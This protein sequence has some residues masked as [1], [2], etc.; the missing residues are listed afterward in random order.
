MKLM[1]LCVPLLISG[2]L[3]ANGL[4]AQPAPAHL[5]VRMSGLVAFYHDPG[6]GPSGSGNKAWA[7]FPMTDDETQRNFLN[8]IGSKEQFSSS[9]EP[10]SQHRMV[11][12]VPMRN[13]TGGDDLGYVRLFPTAETPDDPV[14]NT[15]GPSEIAIEVSSGG[16]PVCLD[17]FTSVP[18]LY[19]AGGTA[20]E[21]TLDRNYIDPAIDDADV[22]SWLA[23]RIAFGNG[24]VLFPCETCDAAELKGKKI[25]V[26]KA[27]LTSAAC[28]P[29]PTSY[30]VS[31]SLCEDRSSKQDFAGDVVADHVLL[32]VD[33]P[34][35]VITRRGK[36]D[37]DH[38]RKA[39]G[40]DVCVH[41]LA[42][43][44]Y[45]GRIDI[46]VKNQTAEDLAYLPTP[47][48]LMASTGHFEHGK[49]LYLLT[50]KRLETALLLLGV[51]DSRRPTTVLHR[52]DAVSKGSIGGQQ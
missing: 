19:A 25:E 18:I 3:G 2:I 32:A 31:S 49:L 36:C 16:S 39:A 38:S 4:G 1:R 20:P 51:A 47:A 48:V 37:D 29:G 22:P 9:G 6:T 13:L 44:P 33:H 34:K 30:A 23:G 50:T 42:L 43:K 41:E 14:A 5:V 8:K 52:G 10:M 40:G 12:D 28:A 45:N 17:K 15:E 21:A 24:W 46:T 35:L 11:I 27:W 7:L 26:M